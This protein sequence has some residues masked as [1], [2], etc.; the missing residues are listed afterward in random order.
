MD[1]LV[2]STNEI[3][4]SLT[5]LIESGGYIP[6]CVTGYSMRP[7]LRHKKDT[8]W[9]KK[10]PVSELKRGRI[11]L[12]QRNDGRLFLHRIRK[13]KKTGVFLMNGDAYTHC[14]YIDSSQ[15][16]GA[17]FEIERNGKR[18]PYD[19]IKL[20]CYEKIWLLLKPLRPFL[21]RVMGLFGVC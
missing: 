16:V 3:K 20:R 10:C 5:D 19:S 13:I 18:I 7:L 17:V 12:Y 8:V 11:I 2:I 4:G 9:I 21:L 14:E 1:K 15:T 6:V